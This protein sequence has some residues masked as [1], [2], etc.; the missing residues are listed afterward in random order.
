M[1][2][3]VT[4]IGVQVTQQITFG[5][6]YSDIN[7]LYGINANPEIVTGLAAVQNALYNLFITQVG[8]VPY[9]RAFGTTLMSFVF[10]PYDQIMAD[11][12]MVMLFQAISTWEPRI[13]V[14][15]RQSSIQPVSGNPFAAKVTIVG[16]LKQQNVPF[17]YNFQATKLS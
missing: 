2:A 16:V 8:T 11:D 9:L 14:N 6:L 10:E 4:P 12:L 5:Q 3:N 15:R 17:V 1:S 7:A 13:F